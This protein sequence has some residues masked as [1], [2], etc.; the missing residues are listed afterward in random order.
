MVQP[1]LGRGPLPSVDE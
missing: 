1:P